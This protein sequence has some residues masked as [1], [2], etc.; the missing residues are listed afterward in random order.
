MQQNRIKAGYKMNGETA[1][2][3]VDKGIKKLRILLTTFI[4]INIYWYYLDLNI[5]N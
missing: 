4:N 1:E 3:E 5:F 2:K